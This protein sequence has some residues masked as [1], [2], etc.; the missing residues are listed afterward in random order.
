MKINTNEHFSRENLGLGV[1][2]PENPRN[3][4]IFETTQLH[5]AGEF[6]NFETCY[7]YVL[8]EL[9]SF[10]GSIRSGNARGCPHT[11]SHQ[12]DTFAPRSCSTCSILVIF[13]KNP[14]H[15]R[16][17]MKNLF[18]KIKSDKNRMYGYHGYLSSTCSEQ[19]N[20]I[21]SMTSSETC[22]QFLQNILKNC[23]QY[24]WMDTIWGGGGQMMSQIMDL[25][26]FFENWWCSRVPSTPTTK[27][28]A[29]NEVSRPKSIPRKKKFFLQ[30]M[31]FAIFSTFFDTSTSRFSRFCRSGDVSVP[32][33]GLALWAPKG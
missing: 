23:I 27:N 33:K 9:R 2:N 19:S 20:S 15:F 21:Q 17:I 14:W 30:K 11:P 4:S 7:H 10:P 12:V 26:G 6:A 31:F 16:K 25:D 8:R 18:Q 22:A 32:T 13:A 3:H 5:D 28:Y 29:G 24:Y 1:E